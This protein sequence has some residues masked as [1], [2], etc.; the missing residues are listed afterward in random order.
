MLERLGAQGV[1]S[2]PQDSSRRSPFVDLS[3]Q[4]ASQ[5]NDGGNEPRALGFLRA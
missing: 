3:R 1:D 5:R 4:L 2:G